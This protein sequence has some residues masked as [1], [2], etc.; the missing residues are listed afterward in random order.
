[1]NIKKLLCLITIIWLTPLMV[2]A[3]CYVNTE[4]SDVR[5][6]VNPKTGEKEYRTIWGDF[7]CLEKE[8]RPL[9][10]MDKFF[11]YNDKWVDKNSYFAPKKEW[12]PWRKCYVW[13]SIDGDFL[14][15]DI[16]SIS[17]EEMKWLAEQDF[18]WWD[19]N[20]LPSDMKELMKDLSWAQQ[21]KLAEALLKKDQNASNEPSNS[22]AQ[23]NANNEIPPAD[24]QSPKNNNEEAT[25]RQADAK[26]QMTDE[27]IR[28]A[29]QQIQEAK[30]QLRA[31]GMTE[32]MGQLEEAEAA[33]NQAAS[34]SSQYKQQRKK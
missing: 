34:V 28:V 8:S 19:K 16:S 18:G 27:E 24:A 12:D 33:L 17:D 23:E 31:A 20:T 2:K 30:R 7:L 3:I 26:M 22:T 29:R 5:L 32:Y 4:S 14:G 6:V 10:D 13:K 25:L 9:Q 21:E 1:M 11:I 15:R